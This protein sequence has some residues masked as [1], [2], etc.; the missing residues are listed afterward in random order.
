MAPLERHERARRAAVGRAARGAPREV[1][2]RAA[3]RTLNLRRIRVAPEARGLIRRQS[4]SHELTHRRPGGG[5]PRSREGT[6]TLPREFSTPRADWLA[7]PRHGAA[8]ER[9]WPPQGK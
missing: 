6:P 8:D 1:R 2:P 4:V 7:P 3:I 9:V 5:Q